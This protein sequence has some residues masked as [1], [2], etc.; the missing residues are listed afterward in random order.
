M[1][2]PVE[3]AP[4]QMRMALALLDSAGEGV[5]AALVQRAIDAVGE[6]E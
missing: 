1:K 4:M 3:V 6:G 2:G 5:A